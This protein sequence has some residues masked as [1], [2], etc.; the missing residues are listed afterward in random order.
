MKSSDYTQIIKK[1][2]IN[3]GIVEVSKYV[4]K[5]IPWLFLPIFSPITNLII[6]KIVFILVEKTEV[7]LFFLYTDMR[8]DQQ[9]RNFSDAVMNNHRLQLEGTED[10]KKQAEHE[11][12][13]SFKTF[14]SFN[15]S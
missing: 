13:V 7:G 11:L 6:S 12:M 14:A 1:A 2:F 8:V 10:E 3:F 4:A 15:R 9:G 5:Q